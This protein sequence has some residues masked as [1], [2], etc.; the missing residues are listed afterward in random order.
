M[1][2]LM[3]LDFGHDT[4][5]ID[6]Q[7]FRQDFDYP[8]TKQ[9][10]F[11]AID[12]TL[13]Q[14][15]INTSQCFDSAHIPALPPGDLNDKIGWNSGFGS[16]LQ[17]ANTRAETFTYTGNKLHVPSLVFNPTDSPATRLSKHRPSEVNTKQ[18]RKFVCKKQNA[19]KKTGKEYAGDDPKR[20]KALQRNRIATSKCREQKKAQVRELETYKTKL[21]H[22]NNSLQQEYTCLVRDVTQ[23]KNQLMA[24]AGCNDIRIDSWITSEAIHF[25][26]SL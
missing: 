18:Q 12:S 14:A 23:L 20:N 11:A 6:S 16:P 2:G 8:S 15:H 5:I 22:K 26:G 7:L 24:H 21:E 17:E 1:G 4:A 13:C 9:S 3:T 10:N 25:V 19:D